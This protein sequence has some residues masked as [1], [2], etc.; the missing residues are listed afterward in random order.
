MVTAIVM[1]GPFRAQI[2]LMGDDDQHRAKDARVMKM[3]G[4]T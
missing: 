1:A 3:E 4:L 2:T